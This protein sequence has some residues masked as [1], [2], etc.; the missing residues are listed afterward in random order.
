MAY[1]DLFQVI[2]YLIFSIVLSYYFYNY[3]K[4]SSEHKLFFLLYL[5]FLLPGRFVNSL[6]IDTIVKINFSSFIIFLALLP[7]FFEILSLEYRKYITSVKKILYFKN[8]KNIILLLI[9]L[10]IIFTYK[11]NSHSMYNVVNFR[12]A[13]NGFFY[14]IN[15]LFFLLFILNNNFNNQLLKKNLH[16]FLLIS[17]IVLS[18]EFLSYYNFKDI[19]YVRFLYDLK[20]FNSI[21]LSS[22]LVT[23]ILSNIFALYLMLQIK[24]IFNF[25]NIS[26]CFLVLI[27]SIICFYNFD[28]RASILSL[29]TTGSLVILY[30]NFKFKKNIFL[31]MIVIFL[32][33]FF[34]STNQT[35][36]KNLILNSIVKNIG[37]LNT[38][39]TCSTES[40]LYRKVYFLREI[41]IILQNF[42]LG[43][44]LGN[45]SYFFKNLY[46]PS[47]FLYFYNQL[48]DKDNINISFIKT[49]E[50]YKN[51]TTNQFVDHHG[52]G[53]QFTNIFTQF[54]AAFG[55]IGIYIFYKLLSFLNLNFRRIDKENIF[56]IMS[57]FVYFING[58]FNSTTGFIFLIFVILY[59]ENKSKSYE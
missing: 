16:I 30:K 18:F 2:I 45:E 11:I 59:I 28:S 25:R 32:S 7:N 4:I 23:S 9:L 27:L 33:F 10:I 48:N 24:F 49:Q 14:T 46:Q 52:S 17:S 12:A 40:L 5:F 22:F 36:C 31:V 39:L 26:Y 37:N 53:S 15:F 51:I 20:N 58:I 43:V 1:I 3:K 56:S 6:G 13:V 55:V 57:I 34:L 8:N 19:S 47:L 41:E 44:G 21:F 38:T 54:F 42:P 29:I 50:I 35:V